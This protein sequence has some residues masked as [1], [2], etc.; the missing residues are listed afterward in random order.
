MITFDDGVTI[1]TSGPLHC[2]T[3][4]DGEFHNKN[5]H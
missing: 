1:D 5:Q 2:L 3:L 4:D